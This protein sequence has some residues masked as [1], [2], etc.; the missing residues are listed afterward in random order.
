MILYARKQKRHRYK[1]QAFGLW[2]KARVGWFERIALKHVY[3]HWN[4]YIICE[5]DC[6]SR[7]NAW[8]RVLKAG[9]LGWP[10]GMGWG[11]RWERSSG[12]GTHVHPWPI[13]GWQKLPQYC[14]VISFHLKKQNKKQ[15][16]VHRVSDAIQPSHPLLSPS[17]SA[18]NLSHHQGLFQWVSSLHQVAKVLS[19]RFSINPLDP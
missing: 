6:Q 16:H 14:K 4:M 11:G 2:E 9:A 7:F 1:E 3:Y 17:P 18:V 10:W 12:W 15:T 13:Y 19:F 8:D 5:I